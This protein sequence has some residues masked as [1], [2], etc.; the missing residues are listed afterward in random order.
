MYIQFVNSNASTSVV[1][2]IPGSPR[3]SDGKLGRAWER[4]YK[5]GND[6]LSLLI[7]DSMESVVKV[8]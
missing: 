6:S 5:S 2:S 1:A 7:A 3:A 8:R 4:G